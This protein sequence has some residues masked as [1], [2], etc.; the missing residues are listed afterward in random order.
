MMG[1]LVPETRWGNKTAYFVA[2][3]WFFTF[4]YAY[5]ARSHEHQLRRKFWNV[6]LE[7]AG[8][9]E[10]APSCEKWKSITKN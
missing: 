6:V 2:S 4:H 10:L 9:D 3:S 5:D 1:I 7:K 8:Q